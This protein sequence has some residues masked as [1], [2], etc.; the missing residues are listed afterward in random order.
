MFTRAIV[1]TPG[2]SMVCGISAANLGTP[3]YEKALAQHREYID[4]LEGCGLQVQVLDADEGYPDST[5][6][7]DV[8][9]LTAHCAVITRPA[10]LSRTG[11]IESIRPV[12]Q[13]HFARI[14][15]IMAPGTLDG[16]DVMQVGDHVYIGLSQ[17]TNLSGAEQLIAILLR[18]G[19]A[20]SI[21]PV[22][23][24]LHLKTGVTWVGGNRLLAAGEFITRPEFA[25]CNILP[26]DAT[27]A[28]AANC[29]RI[30]D[31][32]LMPFRFP[33]V[34]ARLE[35]LAARIIE[36]DISEYAKLDGGLTCLSLR[37]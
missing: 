13:Q 11:E 24:F 3:D 28:A 31:S 8:A 32:I 2:R 30:N 7:E 6:V 36:I 29:I 25:H 26:V 1:R 21:V 23:E 15:Q 20:A 37:F 5:F 34:R 19:V 9:V 35:P 17:R 4:A 22:T 18:Y 16:G 27:D 12:L 14:E 33:Q 10:A